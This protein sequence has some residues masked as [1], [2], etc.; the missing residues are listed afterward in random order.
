MGFSFLSG[1]EF[2]YFFS[3]RWINDINAAKKQRKR[4]KSK[5]AGDC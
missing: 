3:L 1:A 2:I 5:M 4:I